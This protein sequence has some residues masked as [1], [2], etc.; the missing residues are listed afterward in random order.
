MNHYQTT[1]RILFTLITLTWAVVMTLPASA[2][3]L[4]VTRYFSGLW[5]QPRQ[6]SQGIVLQIIDQ[7]ED[8][9]KK[10]VAY[11]FTYGDNL[12]TAWFMAIGHTE[13][14]QVLMNLYTA[15]GVAFMEED[16]PG[17]ENVYAVGTLNLEFKNCNRG[18]ASYDLGEDG[19][20]DFEIKR[21]AGLYH[22]RCSGGISDDTP[23][24]AKPIMLTVALEPAR[25]DISGKGQAK[26]WERVDRSDFHVSAEDLPDGIYSILVCEPLEP[27]GNL[28]VENGE[29]AVQ[30]RSP[31]AEGK[32]LLSFDPR[33]CI[34]ELHDANGAALSSGES[35]LATRNRGGGNGR[36]MAEI[37]VDLENTGVFEGA[38]G[39]ASYR[40][41]NSSTEFEVEI[42]GVA[43]GA[44]PLRVNAVPV[45]QIV[46]TADEDED[47]GSLKGRIR[48]S[49]PQ[50]EERELLNFDPRDQWI[51]V[52]DADD[53]QIIL[54]VFFPE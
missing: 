17:N 22:S 18:V 23:S 3:D 16:A 34:I 39:T 15:D 19:N 49:K 54:E 10:A 25:E 8:G 13:G 30:F 50:K 14:N 20:G 7:E 52:Y 28:V 33:N 24:D 21:L 36:D 41:K 42:R 35:V 12:D 51:E 44:Y 48:F 27:V 32:E 5:D 47:D 37:S 2:A 11:W 26:F 43:E 29:G 45:G 6:E 46:V 31:A 53:A 9:H 38:S 4:A 40:E 1:V